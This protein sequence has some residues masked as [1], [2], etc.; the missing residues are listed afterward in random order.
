MNLLICHGPASGIL[1][2]WLDDRVV[3]SA[4]KLPGDDER[5]LVIGAD[6]PEE[7]V[8]TGGYELVLG[9]PAA[10]AALEALAVEG[11]EG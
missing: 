4:A 2:C 10:R 8:H 3:A 5:W 1:V 9:E 6:V 11:G 7:A